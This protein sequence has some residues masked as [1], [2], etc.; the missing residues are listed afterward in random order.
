LAALWE[1]R[2]KLQPEASPLYERLQFPGHF[3]QGNGS[4]TSCRNRLKIHISGKLSMPHVG[5]FMRLETKKLLFD[6]IAACRDVEQFT[7]GRTLNDL[8]ALKAEAE[9]LLGEKC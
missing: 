6:V 1:E 9:Q 5:S 2:L 7:A 8:P 4:P 3:G